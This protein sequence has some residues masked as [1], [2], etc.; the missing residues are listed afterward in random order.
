MIPG[1][2]TEIIWH[3]AGHFRIIHDIARDRVD[4]DPSA[5]HSR[6][7]DYVTPRPE[8]SFAADLDDFNSHG[9]VNAEALL[10]AIAEVPRGCVLHGH[11]HE[12]FRL[13]L[14]GVR[15]AILG[16]GSATHEGEEGFWLLDIEQDGGMATPGWFDGKGYRLR[17]GAAVPI[18]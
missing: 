14:P 9:L 3:F 1:G 10:R 12:R 7:D 11:I 4:F 15:P 2:S 16:A 17:T 8:H 18:P 5:F 6:P 13:R